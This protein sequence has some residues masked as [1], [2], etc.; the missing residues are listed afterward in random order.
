V[1]SVL[2]L[3]EEPELRMPDDESKTPGDIV[4]SMYD[5]MMREHVIPALRE[6]GFTGTQRKF[7]MLRDGARGVLTWQKDSRA[8][9]QGLVRVTANMDWW[10]GRAGSAS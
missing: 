1:R 2:R 7:T 5:V 10:C 6:F 4:L 3:I 8:Y 9:R